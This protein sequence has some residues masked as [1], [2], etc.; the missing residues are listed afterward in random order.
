MSKDEIKQYRKDFGVFCAPMRQLARAA[1]TSKADVEK[2]KLSY[3][4]MLKNAAPAP[5]AKSRGK[6]Q[7]QEQKVPVLDLDQ[8]FE[9]TV[10]LKCFNALELLQGKGDT[11][12]L[13]LNTPFVLTHCTACLELTSGYKEAFTDFCQLFDNNYTK[14]GKHG[15]AGQPL[16]EDIALKIA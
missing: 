15:R 11:D 13:D 14:L 9:Y 3:D 6:A 16:P 12:A 10:G 4:Q 2:R 8:D 5:K 7:S 1:G